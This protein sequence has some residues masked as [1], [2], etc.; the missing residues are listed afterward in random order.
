MTPRATP[1]PPD[2]RRA[3]ILAVS[4]PLVLEHG[5]RVTTRQ[6]A[7]AAGVAEGTLFRIFPTKTDLLHEVVFAALDPTPTITVLEGID[8]AL[9]LPRRLE[10][11]IAALSSQVQRVT[12]LMT[13]MRDLANEHHGHDRNRMKDAFGARNDELNEAL[14]AVLAP[15]ADGLRLPLADAAAWIRTTVL[16]AAHPL[17]RT[18]GL[19]DPTTLTD[20]LLHGIHQCPGADSTPLSQPAKDS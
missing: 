12:G 11:A 13:A 14:A 3:Q 10:L 9:D 1:L 6:I 5:S 20:V 2:E 16:I 8:P 4:E 7:D 19:A 17:L 15:D 18:P